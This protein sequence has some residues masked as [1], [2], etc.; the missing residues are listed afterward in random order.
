MG[1]VV[2]D[3]CFDKWDDK[4]DRVNG[5]PPL[6]EH[7][8]RHLRALVARDRNHPS[9]VVWSIANEISDMGGR[10][11][12]TKDRVAIMRDIVRQYDDTRPV[13]LAHHI[14]ETAYSDVFDPLDVGGWN[15]DR[16]YDI[17][18]ER[19]PDKPIVYTESASALSTRGFYE[20]PLVGARTDYSKQKQVDSYDLNCAR[21]S[22][23]ADVEFD[24]MERDKFVAGEFVWTG[25]DYLG[26]PTP[27]DR[28]AASSY[29]GIVDTCGMPKDRYYL[30][31]SH[32]RPDTQTVHILPHWNWPD[33]VGKNVPVFVYTNGDSAELFLN[34]KSLGRREKTKQ[35]TPP[36]NIAVG[37][38][39][40]ASRRECAGAGTDARAR[41]RR[42]SRH[43]LGR[44]ERQQGRVVADRL[45][46]RA[47]G[48]RRG[49]RHCGES[50]R[51]PLS[52]RR[53][54]RRQHWRTVVDRKSGT[55]AGATSSRTALNTDA[56]YIR[57]AFTDLRND[58]RAALREF[59]SIHSRTTRSSTSI[60]CGGWT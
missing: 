26:E 10:H 51:L 48:G 21:W 57:V 44:R 40:T 24:L 19:Y 42:Q 35:Y 33:R 23:I 43:R 12:L 46:R 60:A 4:A 37:K 38:P 17:F 20:L 27:F 56:R 39:A 11:G 49:A 22:D 52:D 59:A 32:W 7:G 28:Q 5:E 2:W 3:E 6:E 9:V 50:R 31:R 16:R 34:G 14:P 58:A 13:G 54:R 53:L 45:R 47:A 15:Y 8:K 30:Y 25:F 29:F 1:F 41:Q 18:R 55:K 36:V